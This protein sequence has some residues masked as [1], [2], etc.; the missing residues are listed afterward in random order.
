MNMRR[1]KCSRFLFGLVVL[2]LFLPASFPAQ[3]PPPSVVLDVDVDPQGRVGAI[4]QTLEPG[5]NV[6]DVQ[7]V[8][9]RRLLVP[10]VISL[11]NRRRPTMAV[12]SVFDPAEFPNGPKRT[13]LTFP[14][15]CI[16]QRDASAAPMTPGV[17]GFIFPTRVSQTLTPE[18]FLESFLGDY[19]IEVN[20][21]KFMDS[22]LFTPAHVTAS[23]ELN[24][25][26]FG[27]PG[28][29]VQFWGL[30]VTMK[31][32]RPG[33]YVIRNFM[34]IPKT[35]PLPELSAIFPALGSLPAGEVV[36]QVTVNIQSSC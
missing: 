36:I 2:S 26:L 10:W 11:L 29:R 21:V 27:L 24:G 20:G 6:G 19:M 13:L 9:R 17:V 5:P 22:D 12:E 15:V 18:S 14:P 7:A 16:P 25:L 32:S 3:Q 31:I 1:F 33:T 4:I 23:E 8:V 30:N 34:R 28:V 35:V